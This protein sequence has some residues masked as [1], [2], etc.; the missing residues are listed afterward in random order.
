MIRKSRNEM[1]ALEPY[2]EVLERGAVSQ[3]GRV[4]GAPVLAVCQEIVHRAL[5]SP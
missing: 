3:E 1:A 2:L 5:R 4:R